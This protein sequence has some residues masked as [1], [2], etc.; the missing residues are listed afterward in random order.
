MKI[1]PNNLTGY[2]LRRWRHHA[3][4]PKDAQ[5][6]GS[7]SVYR[8]IA[9]LRGV[10]RSNA[11]GITAS[12]LADELELTLATTHRLLKTLAGQGLLTFDPYSKKYH[13]GL[14]L[15]MLGI[16]AHYFGL[17][18][19]LAGPMR[20]IC[21]A[22]RETVLLLVRSGTDALC[23]QRL[24]GVFPLRALTLSVGARRP[25]G[26]G[27]GG[28]AL[29]SAE[30]DEVVARVLRHNEKFYPDYAD[31]TPAEIQKAVA[32]TRK[33]GFSFN[34]G[35]LRDAVRAVGLAVGPDDE[36]HQAAVSIAT[37]QSR[38]SKSQRVDMEMLLKSELENIDWQLLNIGR[39]GAG[40]TG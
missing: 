2:P 12:V 5:V 32:A 30:T 28:I 35:L 40:R 6:L 13:L 11:T 8:A 14:E 15:Y 37:S 16:E 21:D 39:S 3:N 20:R 17:G 25:L 10:A 23:L 33:R 34:D 9:V 22:S 19:L 4:V 31:V 7:Q 24:D 1:Q 29:L 18:D 26:I 36:T 38:M 27:A